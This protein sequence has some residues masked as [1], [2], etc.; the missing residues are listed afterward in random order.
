MRFVL[1]ALGLMVSAQVPAVFAAEMATVAQAQASQY[2][3]VNNLKSDDFDYVQ[4]DHR[5]KIAVLQEEL[6]GLSSTGGVDAD[7]RAVGLVSQIDA[8][9]TDAQLD[10]QICT[11]EKTMG[12]N[13]V[14][15][16]CRTRRQIQ[17]SAEAARNGDARR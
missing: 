16:V 1:L 11:R 5:E 9:M 17:A 7:A 10:R 3:V 2:V 14:T 15:R 4:R 6:A 13:R 12:S 8:L